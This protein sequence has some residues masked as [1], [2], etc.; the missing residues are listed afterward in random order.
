MAK[1]KEDWVKWTEDKIGENPTDSNKFGLFAQEYAFYRGDQYRV[2]DKR[3]GILREVPIAREARCIYNVCRPIVNLFVAKMLKG[4]PEPRFRPYPDNTEENDKNL[5]AIGNGMSQYWWKT[6]VNGSSKLRHQ[7]Q[8]GGITGILVGKLYF[9]KNK[10]S[11]RYTGEID[12][13][14]VNPFHFFC[15]YDARNDDEMRW[16]IHRFP[17]EKSVVEEE[18][19][20]EKDS[21]KADDKRSIE[22]K[23]VSGG[24]FVDQYVSAEDKST[25]FVHDI[26]IKACKEYPNG[27]HVIVAGKKE[28]VSEDNSEP[29]MLPFFTARVK[30][31]P[32]ELYGDGI[33][34]DILTLQRD[35]N[36]VESIV[37][38][39]AAFM[40]NGKWMVNR[41]SNVSQTALNNEEY[42]RVDY[43]G[44]MPNRVQGVP[45]PE[46]IANRWWDIWRKILLIVGFSEAG[47]G[48]IPFR[49]SQTSPGVI[50]E[51]KSSEDVNFAPEIAELTDY[52]GKVMRRYFFLTRKYYLEP[53]II[54][55]VGENK[56]PEV[57]TYM[58]QDFI[59]D[60]D[61]DIAV[62]SGF[63]QSQEAKMDQMIQFAQTGLFD[64]IPNFN[65]SSFG[66]QVMEYGGLN[67]LSEDTYKDEKQAKYNLQL[68]L[69]NQPAPVSKYTNFP[70][71]IKVFT[72]YT[73]NP[74][75]RDKDLEVR[76]KIDA[77]ISDC[78]LYIQQQ[79]IEQQQTMGGMP[80]QP[81]PPQMGPGNQRKQMQTGTEKEAATAARSS[82]TGQPQQPSTDMPQ[83][84]NG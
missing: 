59:K 4:D 1:E 56:K 17:K 39:N 44:E 2:W 75:Y 18:F 76:G 69:M 43:D 9:D 72:D 22:D 19:G 79:I 6:V 41:A 54:E 71:H 8:W 29:D 45:V 11:G 84:V 68:V 23:R 42:E 70:V 10:K 57:L 28:L 48:D 80:Q 67:K 55:I 37:Q 78:N 33:L 15:N 77:Y 26:W 62:G 30:P 65:W 36:R 20:L 73:K 38:G 63:S 12:F 25:V 64:K 53:R 51:L 24:A 74:E 5:T 14:T 81:P 60:P 3:L 50:K 61:F 47:R 83:Q 27:K 7:C 31:L 82:A 52:V 35:M 34:K 58:A 21:L 16:V 66:E 46:Q 49:G 13:E 32:D 40:G